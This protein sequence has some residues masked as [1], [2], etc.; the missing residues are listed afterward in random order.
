MEVEKDYGFLITNDDEGM[1]VPKKFL[2]IT[3]ERLLVIFGKVMYG[4]FTKNYSKVENKDLV[5]AKDEIFFIEEIKK[6][7][8]RVSSAIKDEEIELYVKGELIPLTQKL[9]IEFNI[10]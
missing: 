7:D 6:N 8:I 3:E 9:N 4:T 5:T 10:Q 2:Y 1:F